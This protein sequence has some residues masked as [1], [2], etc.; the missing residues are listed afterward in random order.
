VLALPTL[1]VSIDL[2]VMLMALPRLSAGLHASR[3]QQ[4]GVN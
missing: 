4:E 3:V 1:L 2:F